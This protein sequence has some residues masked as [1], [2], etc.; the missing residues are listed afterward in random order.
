MTGPETPPR[1]LKFY[2]DVTFQ[3]PDPAGLAGLD[4]WLTVVFEIPPPGPRQTAAAAWAWRGLLLAREWLQIGQVPVFDPPCIISLAPAPQASNWTARVAL[5]LI[6]T[7]PQ[8]LYNDLLN[9]AFAL[10]AWAAAHPPDAENRRKCFAEIEKFVANRL[11]RTVTNGDSTL[12]VLRAAHGLGIP[13][14]HLGGGVYQL[15]WGNRACRIDRAITLRDSAIGARLSG[16]K[17]RTAAL[18]RSAGLPAPVHEAAATADG[19]LAAA[20]RLGWPVVVKPAARDRGEGVTADV[21]D[22]PALRQAFATA[23]EARGGPVLIE[24]QAPGICHR[25]FVA[26]GALLYAMKRWPIAV[27]GDGIHTVAALREAA[28]AAQQRRPPWKRAAIPPLDEVSVRAMAAAGFLPASVPPPGMMVP[29]RNIDSTAWDG[30]GED[31][32]SR[33]HPE[34]TEIAL[35]AAELMSLN[36]AGIDFIS[37][38]VATPWHQNGAI[39]NEVNFSPLLGGSSI[40]R[41]Y[42]NTFLA[43]FCPGGGRIPVEVFFGGEAAFTAAAQRWRDMRDAGTAACLTSAAKTIS[44]AG[45]AWIMPFDSICQRVRALLLS[46][47]TGGIVL[48]V[49][50]D[51]FLHAGLP[52]DAVDAVTWVDSDLTLFGEAA[53][54]P[55]A[56]RTALAQR[57]EDWRKFG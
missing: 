55:A 11:R 34:N 46:P 43:R 32:T 54:L 13:F 8:S 28:A 23:A 45:R 27:H 33:I 26:N 53:P 5:A 16:N 1:Q 6:E 12:A 31:V 57:L 2:L 19:A 3:L 37:T 7:L 49:Q 24:R 52:L 48:A 51:E 22:E 30:A 39:I 40:S 18:L 14:M 47:V 17:A 41:G 25:L 36:V 44:P 38:D 20:Q 35:R 42:V 10:C 4:V 29:L 56:R 21:A 9:A 15:G 50:T